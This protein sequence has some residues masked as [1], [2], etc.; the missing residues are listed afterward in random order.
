MRL[1][2]HKSELT[3]K[4]TQSEK[5][6]VTKTRAQE[7]AVSSQPQSPIPLSDSSAEKSNERYEMTA[8]CAFFTAAKNDPL[9]TI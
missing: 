5:G 3:L 2:G 7:M 9:V 6:S 8:L 4:Q 1:S